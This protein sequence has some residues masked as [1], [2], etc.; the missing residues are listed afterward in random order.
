[1]S[2]REWETDIAVLLLAVFIFLG[3]T[4]IISGR[5]D[6]AFALTHLFA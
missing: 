6:T 1:M 4:L 2:N 5:V 3:I